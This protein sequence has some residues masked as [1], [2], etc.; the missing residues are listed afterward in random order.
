V[1]L[2]RSNMGK[3]EVEELVGVSQLDAVFVCRYL[4]Y[5][6][7]RAKNLFS[8]IWQVLRPVVFNKP[9]CLPRIWN[10]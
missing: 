2:I 3:N 9:A 1:E 5:S 6:A 10:T 8:R 7:E 4:G